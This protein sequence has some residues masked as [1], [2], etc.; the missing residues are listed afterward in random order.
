MI[1]QEENEKEAKNNLKI[2]VEE[3]SKIWI[4]IFDV[5]L[6]FKDGRKIIGSEKDGFLHLYLI[7]NDPKEKEPIQ[8][9]KGNYV[10]KNVWGDEKNEI[11]YFTSTKDTVLETHLYYFSLKNINEIKRYT[12]FLF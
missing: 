11:I 7:S 1:G 10:V 5:K 2:I 9:T 6:F 3:E 8:L 12:F 4:N